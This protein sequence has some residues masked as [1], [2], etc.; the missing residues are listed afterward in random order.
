MLIRRGFDPDRFD[1]QVERQPDVFFH[2]LNVRGELG[3][4]RDQRRVHIDDPALVKGHLPRG[5]LQ[6]DFAGGS[7]PARIGIGE[8]VADI[9]F[10]HGA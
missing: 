5:F 10:S 7:P 9:D 4:L 8:E 2:R 1:V 3:L 6:K